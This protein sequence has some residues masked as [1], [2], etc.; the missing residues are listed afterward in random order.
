MKYLQIYEAFDSNAISKVTK[1]VKEKVGKKHSNKFLN[2]LKSLLRDYDFPIDKISDNDV[3]YL[4]AKK[5][6]LINPEGEISNENGISC[7]KFWFSLEKGFIGYTGVGNKKMENFLTFEKAGNRGSYDIMT[8]EIASYIKNTLNIKTGTLTRVNDYSDLSHGDDIVANFNDGLELSKISK[9]KIYIED[10]SLFGLQ[11]VS[12]GSTPDNGNW[13]DWGFNNSWALGNY[14]NPNGDHSLMYKYTEGD[15][16]LTISDFNEEVEESIESPFVFNLPLG[17]Y[18]KL[19][20]W[21]NYKDE[22]TSLYNKNWKDI[23]QA[24]FSVVLYLDDMLSSN[25]KKRSETISDRE[26]SKKGALKFQSDDDIRK[27]NIDRYVSAIVAKMGIKEDSLDIKNIQKFI[28]INVL[29]DYSYFSIYRNVPDSDNISGFS[30]SIIELM[31]SIKNGDSE[32]RIKGRFDRVVSRYKHSNEDSISY[33]RSVD[34]NYQI[35]SK[36]L[37]KGEQFDLLKD[38]IN[39]SKEIGIH[40]KNHIL[41]QEINSLEEYIFLHN[42]IKSIKDIMMNNMFKPKSTPIKHTLGEMFNN[43]IDTTALINYMKNE[44]NLSDI[45]K[46]KEDLKGLKNV[47]KYI[48]SILN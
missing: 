28:S 32:H 2:G 18:G 39:L 10:R 29:G 9:G 31:N 16:P 45:T 34:K 46:M 47:E 36:A 7:I 30:N 5:A 25:F 35:Y 8:S 11:D 20:N 3:K 48:K 43:R 15:N 22:H 12:G 44:S 37:D 40:I 33:K 42:K 23:E 38:Y 21:S 17:N 4:S 27:A 1:Y 41:K 13:R 26:E 14:T 19:K 24:D 6:L